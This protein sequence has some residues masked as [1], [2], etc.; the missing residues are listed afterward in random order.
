MPGPEASCFLFSF[1]GVRFALLCFSFFATPIF[2]QRDAYFSH[3]L[4]SRDPWAN[5]SNRAVLLV[6]VLVQAFLICFFSRE[7]RRIARTCLFV[8]ILAGRF[9]LFWFCVGRAPGPTCRH[10]GAYVSH[11][12]VL[13]FFQDAFFWP[14]SDKMQD[15]KCEKTHNARRAR[16]GAKQKRI[17]TRRGAGETGRPGAA[18]KKQRETHTPGCQLRKKGKHSPG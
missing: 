12:C 2:G 6:F 3:C 1:R 10:P 18:K 17:R 9:C 11:C 7:S 15:W 16:R 14:G 4:F 5:V 8:A 13:V